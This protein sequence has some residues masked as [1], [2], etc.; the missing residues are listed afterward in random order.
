MPVDPEALEK[1]R[2]LG[3]APGEVKESFA[4]SGGKGGQ[5]VNKVETGVILRHPRSGIVVRVTD[6]RSQARNREIAWQRLAAAFQTRQEERLRARKQAVQKEIRRK[7]RKPRR[8]RE[9][10]LDSKKRRGATKRLR[11]RVRDD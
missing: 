9:K 4:R 3:I 2:R 7:R 8:V 10:I 11:G 1:L 5:N 6:T